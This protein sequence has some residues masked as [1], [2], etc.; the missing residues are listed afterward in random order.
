MSV[1]ENKKDGK[2][3]LNTFLRF[4]G[5]SLKASKPPGPTL[6][7]RDLF[8][9][10]LSF[11]FAAIMALISVV[12][13]SFPTMSPPVSGTCFCEL[14]ICCAEALLFPEVAKSMRIDKLK[15]LVQCLCL[16]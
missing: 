4:P 6:L 7:L 11:L 1:Y 16:S 3:G 14:A 13:F 12:R 8:E 9:D 10:V 2:S 5:S 15:K